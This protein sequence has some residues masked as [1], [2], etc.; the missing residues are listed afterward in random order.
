LK[1]Q[2]KVRFQSANSIRSSKRCSSIWS[3]TLRSFQ[4]PS[5]S[6]SRA[7][8]VCFAESWEKRVLH[9]YHE[10]MRKS[11]SHLEAKSRL[12]SAFFLYLVN[13]VLIFPHKTGIIAR[14]AV[15]PNAKKVLLRLSQK[16][17]CTRHC[18]ACI[19]VA[20]LQGVASEMNV[21]SEL[22]TSP[23]TAKILQRQEISLRS[24]DLRQD[25][26]S[27]SHSNNRID[28]CTRLANAIIDERGSKSFTPNQRASKR[29]LALFYQRVIPES[30]IPL[31]RTRRAKSFDTGSP[32]PLHS[33]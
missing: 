31:N 19:H 22:K 23:N 16:V 3:T 25:L 24:D 4:C 5:C 8:L 33:Q 10:L 27:V 26:F 28:L 17:R 12:V 1:S 20:Q 13:P 14:D 29:M 6:E 9:F 30:M 2:T 18:I 15:E 7:L 11:L 32:R 21:D